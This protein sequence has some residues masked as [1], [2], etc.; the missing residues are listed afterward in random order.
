M[1]KEYEQQRVYIDAPI[2]YRLILKNDQKEIL[3]EI[4]K[5]EYNKILQLHKVLEVLSNSST[6]TDPN[7]INATSVEKAAMHFTITCGREAVECIV[8][9]EDLRTSK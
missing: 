9:P 2:K 7:T 6:P 1:K 3:E 4:K 8:T 5:L